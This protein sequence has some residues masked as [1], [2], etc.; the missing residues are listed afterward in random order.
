M[1]AGRRSPGGELPGSLSSPHGCDGSVVYDIALS[2]LAC[3]R[4]DTDVHVAWVAAGAGRGS[5]E[6]VAL[7]PGGGR[8]GSLLGG[9][10]DHLLVEALP[11]LGSDGGLLH[12]SIGPA[13]SIVSGL[14]EGRDLTVAIVPGAT[15]PQDVWT[16]LA[17][18]EPVSFALG[19]DGDRFTGVESAEPTNEPVVLAGSRL[20]CTFTP[21][22]RAVISGGGPIADALSDAFALAGWHASVFTDVGA[23]EGVMATLSPA[24]AVVV[25]GHDVEISGRAL[26]AAIRSNAGY[27]GS[28]GSK[29]MQELRER[30][31]SFRGVAWTD[32][33]HGPA[34]LHIGASTPGEIAISIV[35]EAVGRL[36]GV[37]HPDG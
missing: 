23:A 27:I 32:R 36:R 8:M 29:Q 4:A 1:A 34:G 16:A 22:T 9:A 13:E 10:V 26:Q 15:L 6:A 24:D 25:L 33:I 20:T 12:V 7:T 37:S 31:L 30:W 14:P 28:V 11:R 18:R 19:I 2:V 3:L 5:M 21:T 17:D 35:A